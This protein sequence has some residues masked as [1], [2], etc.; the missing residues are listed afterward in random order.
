MSELYSIKWGDS[1]FV[2]FSADSDIK[3][4][5][6]AKNITREIGISVYSVFCGDRIIFN[7]LDKLDDIIDVPLTVPDLAGTILKSQIASSIPYKEDDA[8]TAND[9]AKEQAWATSV[10]KSIIN[11]K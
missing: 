6:L 7:T 9:I 5:L 10:R 2:K 1:E 11:R 3:A 8:S 4:K